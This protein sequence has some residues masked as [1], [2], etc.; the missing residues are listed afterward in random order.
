MEKSAVEIITDWIEKNIQTIYYPS[1]EEKDRKHFNQFDVKK[2]V[3]NRAFVLSHLSGVMPDVK[4]RLQSR[5]ADVSGS[6]PL[7]ESETEA[8]KEVYNEIIEFL[9][10]G[11]NYDHARAS[12]QEVI[13]RNEIQDLLNKCGNEY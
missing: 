9:S 8:K 4:L 7:T 6:L 11:H 1:F 5:K 10:S 12:E 2:M 13:I 3:F